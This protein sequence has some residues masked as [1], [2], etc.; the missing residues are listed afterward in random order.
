[1]T[2]EAENSKPK[3]WARK[4]AALLVLIFV[5]VVSNLANYFYHQN[6]RKVD[7]KEFQEVVHKV[8]D[9]SEDLLQHRV[10]TMAETVSSA[11]TNGIK[12]EMIRGNYEQLNTFL[13]DM[14]QKTELDLVA[15]AD[16]IGIIIISTDKKYEGQRVKEVLPSIDLKVER[17]MILVAEVGGVKLTGPIMAAD[18]RLGT[19]YITFKTDRE[20]IA[21]LDNIDAAA[22][23]LFLE[24]DK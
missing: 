9:D 17:P 11:L 7:R 20:T 19:L 3:G 12:A 18:H 2:V 8:A 16:T 5:L 13:V 23:N 1:M 24:Q 14:V 15:I 21:I 10:K 6:Q 22:D 4:N